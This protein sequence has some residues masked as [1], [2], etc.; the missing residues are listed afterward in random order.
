MLTLMR[1]PVRMLVFEIQPLNKCTQNGLP[2]LI[3]K[4]QVS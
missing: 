4:G 2:Q 3:L 1:Q